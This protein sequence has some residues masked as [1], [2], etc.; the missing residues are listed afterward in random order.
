MPCDPHRPIENLTTTPPPPPTTRLVSAIISAIPPSKNPPGGTVDRD[1]CNSMT[2]LQYPLPI[3]PSR[4]IHSSPRS[5]NPVHKER[6]GLINRCEAKH[7]SNKTQQ[8]VELFFPHIASRHV[9]V[10]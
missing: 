4:L 5:K 8:G 6:V 9:L 10:T 7:E 2:A 3:L 1:V